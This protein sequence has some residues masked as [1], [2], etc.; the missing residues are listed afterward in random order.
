ML[1]KNLSLTLAVVAGG[2]IAVI[3]ACGGGDGNPDARRFDAPVTIDGAP[4]AEPPPVELNGTLTLLESELLVGDGSGGAVAFGQG[5]A[6]RM[7]FVDPAAI[8]AP[9]LEEQPGSPFGCKAFEYTPAQFVAT[10]GEDVGP[11]DLTYTNGPNVPT[12]I[13]TAGVGYACPALMT[14]SAGD[15]AVIG[16]AGTNIWTFTDPDV[17]YNASAVG[18]YI[19]IDGA[20]DAP[21]NGAFPIVAQPGPNTIVFASSSAVAAAIVGGTSVTIAGVGPIPQVPDPGFIADDASVV[22]DLATIDQVKFPSFTGTL[23]DYGDDF[24][25]DTEGRATMVNIPLTDPAVDIVV[26]C[27]PNCGGATSSVLNVQTSDGAIAGLSPFTLPPPATKSVLVRC[28][29]DLALGTGTVTIPAAYAQYITDSGATRI[30]A[31]FV[32][33][34][35]ASGS[36]VP[37]NRLTIVGGHASVGFTT[38]PPPSAAP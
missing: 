17:T 25:L 23:A 4:D 6:F 18:R 13:F 24:D 2:G 36:G 29:S 38:V 16:P 19:R 11:V 33:G 22:I 14:A 30:Q 1:L 15:N 35:L 20:T 3:G 32:R 7:A 21:N 5:P 26:D 12:C 10:L 34:S 9:V 37:S 27:E 8:G 28:T 31:T